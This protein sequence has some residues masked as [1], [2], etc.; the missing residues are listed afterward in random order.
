MHNLPGRRDCPYIEIDEA[1]CN[2]CVLCMKVC[3]TKAI[4][5]KDVRMAHIVGDCISCGECVHVCPRGAIRAVTT[6]DYDLDASRYSA[7]ST[8]AVAYSQ[9]GNDV[10]PNDILLALRRMG[11]QYVFDHAYFNE[12]F[13]VALEF[14]LREHSQREDPSWPLISPVCPVVVRL[15]ECR[16]PGLLDH[17]PPLILP[18]EIVAREAKKRII[19]K[20]GCK[21]E[22]IIFHHVSPCSAKMM[23][24]RQPLLLERSYLNKAIGINQIFNDIKNNI[25]EP[26]EEMILH[27]SGG[28]GILWGLSGGEIAGLDA[29][30]LAVS[31]LQET[32]DYLEKI[33]MGLF[34]NIE[35][36]EF[37]ICKEGC[38]GGPLTVIDKYEAKRRLQRL[39]RMFGIENRVKPSHIKKLYE[40]GWFSTDRKNTIKKKRSPISVT[41]R[42]DRL[43]RVEKTLKELPGKECGLCG[44]PDCR[45]LAEDIVDGRT[46]LNECPFL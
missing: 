11:F 35:Y 4:R 26:E 24:I 20:H 7:V 6:Q 15:I 46:A 28:V 3:P 1:T 38:L 22:E 27:H 17:I 39:G 33:E 16:F 31:G 2:G 29:R 36:M 45:T 40:Q 12:M 25:R 41:D 18:R 8:V 30:C 10:M 43:N 34:N 9:F 37:R 42:I 32:I 13:S 44:A 19:A 23:Y 5:V 21:P 14:F